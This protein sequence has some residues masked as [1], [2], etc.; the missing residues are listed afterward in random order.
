MT[1][2]DLGQLDMRVTACRVN[3]VD[4]TVTLTVPE[5]RMLYKAAREQ[6]AVER[7]RQL[8]HYGMERFV[9]HCWP[10]IWRLVLLPE[11]RRWSFTAELDRVVLR[12]YEL[13][14]RLVVQF[15]VAGGHVGY[16]TSDTDAHGDRFGI[17]SYDGHHGDHAQAFEQFVG[18]AQYTD[19]ATF[20]ALF[21]YNSKQGLG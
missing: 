8:P 2:E 18:S 4:G 12:I 9:E 17:L 13:A 16:V 7:A 11:K 15:D 1:A 21:R 6:L 3:A 19:E 5:Y 10:K 20:A 14:G